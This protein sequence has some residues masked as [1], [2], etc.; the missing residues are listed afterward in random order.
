[1]RWIAI[2]AGLLVASPALAVT[3]WDKCPTACT[4]HRLQWREL[5]SDSWIDVST[6]PVGPITHPDATPGAVGVDWDGIPGG[7][8]GIGYFQAQ[9]MRNGVNSPYSTVLFVGEAPVTPMLLASLAVVGFLRWR[10]RSL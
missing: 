7:L 4:S 8:V 3:S 10:R 5:P 2:V 9:A 1:M 6:Q